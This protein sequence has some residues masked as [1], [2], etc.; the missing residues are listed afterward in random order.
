MRRFSLVFVVVYV[1]ANVLRVLY[2]NS[3]LFNPAVVSADWEA[4]FVLGG[5]ALVIGYRLI[6]LKG[7]SEPPE[8]Y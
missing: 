8:D 3:C 7:P 1:R 5:T 4:F 2:P 6:Q